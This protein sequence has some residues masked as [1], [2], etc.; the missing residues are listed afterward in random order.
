[1]HFRPQAVNANRHTERGLSMLDGAMVED[2]YV[3]PMT[4]AADGE[5]IDGSARLVRAAERF[6]GEALVIEHDGTRPIVMRRTDIPN[7][8]T[9]AAKRIAVRANRIAEVDLAWD[10]AVLASLPPAITGALWSPEELSALT[11]PPEPTAV[12]AEPQIDRAAELQKQWGTKRG[13]LWKLGAH[14]LCC[15]DSTQA[16]DVARLMGGATINIAFTSPPYAE[17]RTYDPA[18]GFKPIPPNEYVEWFAAVAANVARHLAADGSWFVNIKPSCD[19]LD[20]H[21]YVHDLVAHHVRQWG[22]HFAT[23]FCWER[24]GVPKSVTQRFKNQFEPIFQFAR[25]R[26][27]MRPDNVRHASPNVPRAGGAGVGNTTWK[28]LQGGTGSQSVSGSFGGAKRRRHGTSVR[29]ADMQGRNVAPGEFIGEGLAY[30][31]NRLPPMAASHD[32]VGHTAAFPVGLP[33]FFIGAFTDDGDAVYD[34]FLGSCSTILAAQQAHRIGYG[35]EL[36]PLLSA[37]CLQ[38]F[39]DATGIRPEL[40]AGAS[41]A[42]TKKKRKAVEAPT[43]VAEAS[44]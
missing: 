4:A 3:A 6:D 28:D 13:Q 25:G 32:A 41:A 12:D 21:L 26:W 43:A 42:A 24:N 34:P 11:L 1:M 33:L 29:M 19:G 16:E 23:E 8:E 40:I 30:P 38:R 39:L 35:M 9:E 44:A 10:P 37:V 27:K 2:G 22:W 15:G 20:T 7:A 5:V 36:S 17:Q 31:G 18:S 14:R